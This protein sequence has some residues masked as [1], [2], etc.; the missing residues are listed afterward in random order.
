[1]SLSSL[2]S[3]YVDSDTSPQDREAALSIQNFWHLTLSHCQ[4]ELCIYS[5]RRNVLFRNLSQSLGRTSSIKTSFCVPKVKLGN[6]FFCE[7]LVSSPDLFRDPSAERMLARLPKL[8]APRFCCPLSLP[9]LFRSI[10]RL[11]MPVW[12]VDWDKSSPAKSTRAAKWRS[13]SLPSHFQWNSCPIFEANR[14]SSLPV[15]FS[16]LTA[17]LV[18]M[19]LWS[20]ISSHHAILTLSRTWSLTLCLDLFS[21]WMERRTP[22]T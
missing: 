17:Q 5:A 3:T 18:M 4:K 21:L 8:G 1:M 13:H 19:F 22:A 14:F 16:P 9:I 7:L 12:A 10:A 2:A 15:F 11:P 6:Y 20:S